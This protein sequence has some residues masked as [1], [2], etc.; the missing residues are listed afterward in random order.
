MS[1]ASSGGTATSAP[2]HKSEARLRQLLVGGELFLGSALSASL[3]KM[4]LRAMDLLGE[5]SPAAKEM[6][7][8]R[9]LWL[10]V[11][12]MWILLVSICGD[13]GHNIVVTYVN[14][15][16]ITFTGMLCFFVFL[17]I[18]QQSLHFRPRE[19]Y[20]HKVAGWG[21]VLVSAARSAVGRLSR[22]IFVRPALLPLLCVAFVCTRL[23]L[24]LRSGEVVSRP[25]TASPFVKIKS[26]ADVCFRRERNH[27]FFFFCYFVR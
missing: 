8:L 22:M 21:S 11:V 16:P 26:S 10:F 2:A 19:W 3:T 5:S 14:M 12:Y 25:T 23:R 9:C 7:V 24:A 20:I 27:F 1:W 13:C 18:A 6:Q 4:T 17:F 15:V